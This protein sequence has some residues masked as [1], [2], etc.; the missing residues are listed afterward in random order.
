[1]AAEDAW[2][3]RVVEPAHVERIKAL[4]E[5]GITL[6][7]YGTVRAEARWAAAGEFRKR[8]LTAFEANGIELARPA[9]VVLAGAV[10]AASPDSGADAPPPPAS[11]PGTDA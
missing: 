5:N 8:L 3:D 11:E 6:K 7:I 1:M 10:Q 4:G 9:R 2:R